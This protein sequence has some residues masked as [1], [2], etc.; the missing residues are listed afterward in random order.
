MEG[1]QSCA[2]E[3]AENYCFLTRPTHTNSNR[4]ISGWVGGGAV[5]RAPMMTSDSPVGIVLEACHAPWDSASVRYGHMYM[6]CTYMYVRTSLARTVP[7]Y[8]PWWHGGYCVKLLHMSIW[9]RNVPSEGRTFDGH[10]RALAQSPWIAQTR[11]R[12][13]TI[14]SVH[15]VVVHV[16]LAESN[17][18]EPTIMGS[19]DG[20]M[21]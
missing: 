21:G 20:L 6:Y 5:A 19:F 15:V 18:V 10:R 8:V 17:A 13:Y 11:N 7:E 3:E 14:H 1:I 2:G 16:K 4:V 9:L 12:A